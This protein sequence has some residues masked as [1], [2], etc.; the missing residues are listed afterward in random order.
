MKNEIDEKFRIGKSFFWIRGR[1]GAYH[2]LRLARERWA[3]LGETETYSGAMYE[4]VRD[5]RRG[6]PVKG[7]GKK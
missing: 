3:L 4:I 5:L 7:T 2:V 6:I 1:E